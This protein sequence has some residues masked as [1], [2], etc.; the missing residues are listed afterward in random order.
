M[1]TVTSQNKAEFDR[2]FL[3]KKGLIKDEL[4]AETDP[5]KEAESEKAKKIENEQTMRAKKH[6]KYA[7][8]KA[9]LG[10]RGAVDAILKELNDKQ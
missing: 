9:A 10:H 8:L 6:P 5:M 2:E 7:R 3:K 1:P 4:E